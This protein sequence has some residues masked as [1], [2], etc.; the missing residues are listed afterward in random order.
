MVRSSSARFRLI[1]SGPAASGILLALGLLSAC[2]SSEASHRA[3][4]LPPSSAPNSNNA[5]SAEL[6]DAAADGD[7]QRVIRLL[8]LAT[9][10][11]L[12]D[13]E[14]D[15]ALMMAAQ[16]GHPD[17]VAA[18]LAGG[19]DPNSKNNSGATAL[20]WGVG[21]PRVVELLLDHGAIPDAKPDSGHTALIIAANS[22]GTSDVAKLLVSRGA[23]VNATALSGF[24]PLHSATFSGDPGLIEL[25]LEKGADARAK[26]RVGWT[27]LH[28]A[29]MMGNLRM[30]RALLEHGADANSSDANGYT[31]LIWASAAGSSDVVE[32]LLRKG[33]DPNAREKFHGGPP[34]I[35]AASAGNAEVAKLLLAAGADATARD[36][37]RNTAYDWA[38]RRGEAEMLKLFG[39]GIRPS[40]HG[41]E[42]RS[43]GIESN[44]VVSA[45]SRSL[46]LLQRSG[47]EFVSNSAENCVSCHHQSLPAMAFRLASE[48]GLPIDEKMFRD[49]ATPTMQELAPRRE[50]LM[51]G[52]GVP[53][54]LDPAYLLLA[55]GAAK[56]KPDRATDALVHFLTLK[57][58]R[59]GRWRS[60]LHRPPMDDSD[61]TSTAISLRALA[62]FTPRGRREEIADRV[63]R[64]A[65][66][67][68]TA[69]P[70]TTEDR[71]MQLLGLAWANSSGPSYEQRASE[72]L[73]MQRADGGWGQLP[74]LRSDAYATGE[75][76]FALQQSG[77][78][79]SIDAGCRRGVR[80]LLKT[81]RPDGSW[82]VQ[83]RSLPVQ[84]YFESGF[85]YRKS[86]FISC[87]ATSWAVMALA[88][89]L[90]TTTAQK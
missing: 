72:L 63:K 58:S 81:Q 71:A 76:L 69:A 27:A 90:P 8:N 47:S 62:L 12:R 17:V 29:A 87:A 64:A 54:P 51:L 46:P 67:L 6:A 26:N 88:Q 4:C 15:T 36:D 35:Y 50:R 20:M 45:I 32:L 40:A 7:F 18:L 14:G 65:T 13:E 38:V 33:A 22:D 44:G 42:M 28:G 74:G 80:F 55:L 56:Q 16:N 79:R 84:P 23:K 70:K 30:V 83:T 10:V 11:N 25:L 49:I 19:A 89:S 1:I 85:P 3:K 39:H 86:Q 9:N 53:D 61:F 60:V 75:V 41:P 31:P 59:D 77:H 37:D 68:E 21:S 48:R 57:Q 43:T 2:K 78:L 82:F 34:L 52:I 5:A 66:W 24:T 73:A